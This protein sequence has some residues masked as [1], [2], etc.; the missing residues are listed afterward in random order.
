MK[1][2]IKKAIV[3]VLILLGIWMLTLT[4]EP[5]RAKGCYGK[6]FHPKHDTL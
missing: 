6:E 2:T 5:C 1:T 4:E 3:V